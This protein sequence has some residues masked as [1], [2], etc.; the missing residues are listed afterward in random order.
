MHWPYAPSALCL[1]ASAQKSGAKIENIM[2][3]C[4]AA[5]MA[6]CQGLAI[7]VLLCWFHVKQVGN[8]HSYLGL[9]QIQGAMSVAMHRHML[10][11]PPPRLPSPSSAE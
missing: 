7:A 1:R 4:S 6:A 2:M 5:A 9:E 8:V 3:D 11:S 10:A